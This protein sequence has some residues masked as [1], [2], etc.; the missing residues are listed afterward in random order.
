M[1]LQTSKEAKT[2]SLLT[3]K[4]LEEKLQVTAVTIWRWRNEGMPFLRLKNSIRFEEE[5]V[6]NWLQERG[7]ENG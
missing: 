6:L 7:R 2:L 4:Q 3:T 1:K 5:K